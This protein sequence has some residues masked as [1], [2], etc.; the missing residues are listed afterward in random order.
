MFVVAA[1]V[2]ETLTGKWLGDF[3]RE[4]I[5]EPL[6][7]DGTVSLVSSFVAMCFGY[8]DQLIG[9]G[10]ERV[11]VWKEKCIHKR[12]LCC[13][14]DMYEHLPYYALPRLIIRLGA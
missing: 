12:G 14:C 8:G 7:M 3:L 10:R 1:H 4:R 11:C 6:G 13:K 2:V 5:W 9:V